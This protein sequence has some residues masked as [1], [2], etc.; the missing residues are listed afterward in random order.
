VAQY[1]PCNG[2]VLLWLLFKSDLSGLGCKGLVPLVF[3]LA[4][5]LYSVIYD[6]TCDLDACRF[7][8]KVV[9]NKHNIES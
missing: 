8:K 2:Y 1:C 9:T 5:R 4:L 6:S 7:V 3:V